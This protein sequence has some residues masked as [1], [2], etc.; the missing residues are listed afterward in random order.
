M[1]FIYLLI[2][3]VS[4]EKNIRN[5]NVPACKNCIH[6]KPNMYNE[7]TS[8]KS[9]C[10]N[11]GYKDII[12]GEIKYDFAHFCRNDEDK[13]GKEGKFFSEEKNINIK[14]IKHTIIKKSPYALKLLLITLC[15]VTF[16]LRNLLIYKI[17]MKLLL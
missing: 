8:D 15:I 6:Y 7:F 2:Y 3:L 11:F 1:K 4:C 12:T 5:I 16:L 14:L 17:K 9:T 10:G 13:C